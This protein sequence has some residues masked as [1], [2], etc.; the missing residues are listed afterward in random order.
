MEMPRHKEFYVDKELAVERY[1]TA[2]RSFYN[3]LSWATEKPTGFSV[4]T[5]DLHEAAHMVKCGLVDGFKSAVS[6]VEL[7]V[8]WAGRWDSGEP[9][10]E[11]GYRV[12][13]T[14]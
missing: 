4:E 13:F 2:K 11:P 7:E 8:G 9:V 6:F 12:T 14:R 10:T 5:D 1:N 3:K